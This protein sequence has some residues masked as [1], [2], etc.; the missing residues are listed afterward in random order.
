M[1]RLH[2]TPLLL[3][4][5]LLTTAPPGCAAKKKK[6]HRVTVPVVPHEYNEVGSCPFHRA[7]GTADDLSLFGHELQRDGRMDEAL[8]CY[9]EAVRNEPKT[10]QGWFD[11]AVARQYDDPSQALSFYDQ[12]LSLDPKAFHYNQLGIMLRQN[13]RQK[14]ASHRFIQASRLAPKDAV[15]PVRASNPGRSPTNPVLHLRSTCAPASAT[16]EG[17]RI[18]AGKGPSV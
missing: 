3:M 9:A 8:R 7:D 10:A 12:G 15:S 2:S 18:P 11:L 6:K 16:D 13:D 4:L 5:M 1:L 17:V 14:E